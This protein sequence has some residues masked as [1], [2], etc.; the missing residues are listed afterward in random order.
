VFARAWRKKDVPLLRRLTVTTHGRILYSWF[1]RHQPPDGVSSADGEDEDVSVQIVRRDERTARLLVRVPVGRAGNG[2]SAE[3]RLDWE[4]R[5]D[6]WYF[7][8][9]PR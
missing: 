4:R 7:V 9:P 1:V 8:P 6:T 2:R 5:G 3:L